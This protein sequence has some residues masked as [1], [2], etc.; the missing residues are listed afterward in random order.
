MI[1]GPEDTRDAMPF[2]TLLSW[3]VTASLGGFMLRTWL[4]RGGLD[5]ERARS[6]GLPSPLI[7]ATPSPG[8]ATALTTSRRFWSPTR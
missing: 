7:F 2:A 1:A 8:P 5:R 3:L 6:G 4:A